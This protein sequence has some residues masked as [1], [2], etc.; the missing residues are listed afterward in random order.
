[1]EYKALVQ[2]YKK[3]WLHVLCKNIIKLHMCI[4]A[5]YSCFHLLILIGGPGQ[6]PHLAPTYAAVLALCTVGSQE[7]YDLI[8][9]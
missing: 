9:R 5:H 1:M 8:N 6:L 7:A 3:N 2:S 4:N